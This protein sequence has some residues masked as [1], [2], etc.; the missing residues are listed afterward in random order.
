MKY[1]LKMLKKL[2]KSEVFTKKQKIKF[3]ISFIIG[4]LCK[5]IILPFIVINFIFQKIANFCDIIT[6]YLLNNFE[7]KIIT[8]QE[9]RLMYKIFKKD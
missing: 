2:L 3:I 8:P 6:N 5:L 7:L 4:L 1:Y 9:Q